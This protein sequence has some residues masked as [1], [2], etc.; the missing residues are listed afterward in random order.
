MKGDYNMKSH[1]LALFYGFLVWLIP[2]IIAF[3]IHPIR[4]SNRALFESIMPIV[5]TICVV[6]FSVFYLRKVKADFFREGILLGVIWFAISL[7]I[8]LLMFMPKSPMKMSFTDYMMDI[9]VI[10]LIIPTISVGIGYLLERQENRMGGVR[11]ST[12]VSQPCPSHHITADKREIFDFPKLPFANSFIRHK[13]Q[14]KMNEISKDNQKEFF[15]RTYEFDVREPVS[16]YYTVVKSS[17]DYYETLLLS[18]C[19]NKN[20]LE[21]GCGTGSYAFSLAEYGSKVIGIDIS[22]TAIRLAKERAK[23]EALE[24]IQFLVMDAEA[25]QFEDNNF[26]IVCGTAILHHLNLHKAMSELTRVLNPTGKAIFIEPMGHNPV[27]NLY[28]KLTPHFRTKDE[29]PLTVKDLS[30]IKEFFHEVDWRYFHLFSLLAVPFRNK[31]FFP[32]LL[33]ILDTIDRKLFKWAPFIRL[34]AWQVVIILEKPKK[35]HFK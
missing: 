1:K 26:D 14:V 23:Q 17:R 19:R 8:D 18:N 11:N 9:G 30:L 34:F 21:Y 16:K 12:V 28:R 33:K 24:N 35:A 25:M 29:H 5:L 13:N 4:T 2:F 22:E 31:K 20:V 7:A 32:S 27:I 6:L 10:Y 3:L 15:D